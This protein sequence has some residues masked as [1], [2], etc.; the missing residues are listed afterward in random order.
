MAVSRARLDQLY[1]ELFDRTT[2][3]EDAGAE[4]WMN[5]GLTGEALRDALIAGA[6]SNEGS[7]DYANFQAAQEQFGQNSYAQRAFDVNQMY[8]ELF[9]RPAEQAGLEYWL[10]SGL[11]GEKLRDSIAYAGFTQGKESVDRQAYVDRQAALAAG[12]TPEGYKTY[13]APSQPQYVTELTEQF[14]AMQ[15]EIAA[16]S[17]MLNAGGGGYS[18][19]VPV[20]QPG[21]GVVSSGGGGG[22]SYTVPTVVPPMD[23]P[24]L[25]QFPSDPPVGYVPPTPEMLD[26][27]RYEQFYNQGMIPPVDQ[28]IGALSYFGIPPSQIQTALT[29]F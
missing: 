9:G 15:E 28:G 2:G 3:A 21:G 17:A 6:A 27:Y 4:Y 22:S 18:P 10:N 13:M 25:A 23:N 12:D 8:K 29:G 14:A 7:T 1:N 11:S 26:A 19:T 20:G 24:Y 5:S 16:L